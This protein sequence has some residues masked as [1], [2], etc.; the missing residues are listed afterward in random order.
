MRKGDDGEIERGHCVY[1]CVYVFP[2]GR[3][4]DNIRV[5]HME[6]F[7]LSFFFYLGLFIC[8]SVFCLP[9]FYLHLNT[10][11][12]W[13]LLPHLLCF[14]VFIMHLQFLFS[15]SPEK[16]VR[17]CCFVVTMLRWPWHHL[18]LKLK[19][20]RWCHNKPVTRCCSLT[21]KLNLHPPTTPLSITQYLNYYC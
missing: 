4:E 17:E 13:P 6:Q 9:L 2:S 15:F 8:M 3:P 11:F 21:G 5:P 20:D 14:S 10:D 19:G 7:C 16:S 12:L 1:V 18:A